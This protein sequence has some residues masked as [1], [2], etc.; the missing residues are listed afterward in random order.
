M[1]AILEVR[2]LT[3]DFHSKKHFQQIIK[4]IEFELY[5]G[6]CLGILGESGSGKSMSAK[7]IMGLLD[8]SFSVKGQAN[9][10]GVNL[11]N[12]NEEELRKIR[13]KSIC[14]ILQNPMTCFD[15]LYRIGYQMEETYKEHSDMTKGEIK[16]KSLQVL[17]TMQIRDPQE[18]LKKYP[19]QLSGGMLQRIMIG[20][21]I[22]MKPD[23]L[24]ADEPTTAL[25]SI[26]QYEIM[27]EFLRIKQETKA[28]MIFIS[29]DLSVIGQISDEVLVMNKGLIA[30]RGSFHE[31]LDN[32]KDSYTK[33]LV[34]KRKAVMERYKKVFQ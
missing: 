29:H 31:I 34:E 18:V 1:K 12:K 2:N 30:D 7:A 14:M 24:I 20:I 25:D 11:L 22:S 5:P 4:G 17:E 21:A 6:K 19:H 15:P 33:L 9:Y 8:R 27:K 26:T 16:Q 13:G 32:A 3:V 10:R 23:I 28:A